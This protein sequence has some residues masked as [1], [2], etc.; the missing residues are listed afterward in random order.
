MTPGMTNHEVARGYWDAEE[1]RDLA[2]VLAFYADDAVLRIQGRELRGKEEIATFYEAN[3]S[4]FPGLEIA[5][6][7]EITEGPQSVF[8]VEATSIDHDGGRHSFR[9]LNAVRI[10]NGVF[11]EVR[12]Y[13]ETALPGSD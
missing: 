3:F 12:A 13:F 1:R 11:A 8:E 5:I 10:E 6:F 9:A 7:N 2:G 4:G